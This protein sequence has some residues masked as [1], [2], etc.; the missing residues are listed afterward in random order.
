[1]SADLA[2]SLAVIRL[3][4]G[5]GLCALVSAEI[6]ARIGIDRFDRKHALSLVGLCLPDGS[7]V[8]PLFDRDGIDVDAAVIGLVRNGIN[9]DTALVRELNIV[10]NRRNREQLHDHQDR[11]HYR[12]EASAEQIVGQLSH[13]FCPPFIESCVRCFCV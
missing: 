8:V 6:V 12:P 11:D 2:V 10:R 5:F 4:G 9:D 1:M 13:V 3:A 7:N